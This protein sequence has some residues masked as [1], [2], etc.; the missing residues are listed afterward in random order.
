MRPIYLLV[1]AA[2]YAWD[3]PWST[4]E[5]WAPAEDAP[6][7][8]EDP[9]WVDREPCE[10]D[11][12]P[13]R[14]EKRGRALT[15]NLL[16]NGDARERTMDGWSVVNGGDGWSAKDGVFK[17]SFEPNTRRQVVDLLNWVE[18]SVLDSG[19]VE[20]VLG[21]QITETGSRDKYFIGRASGGPGSGALLS[22]STP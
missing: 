3:F 11:T 2:A 17:T 22:R 10:A 16:R 8:E 1:V 9:F 7:P 15:G 5:G 12:R 18:A 6:R 21:E 14:N 4:E 19:K 13:P 20:I